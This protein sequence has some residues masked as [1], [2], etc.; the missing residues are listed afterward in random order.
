MSGLQVKAQPFNYILYYSK[1]RSLAIQIKAGEVVVRA[2]LA[3]AM[4]KIEAFLQHKQHW[5]LEKIQ[6]TQLLAA[7]K[8]LEEC[9]LPLFEQVLPFEV[10]RAKRSY[11]LQQQDKLVL[12][13]SSRVQMARVDII[14]Q[15]LITDWYKQQAQIWFNSRV[16]YW[17]RQ[18]QVKSTEIVI[19]GWLSKWG[20]CRA[21]G[22]LG[23][24]WR[25][26]MAPA[27]VA[28]YVVVHEV[29][30]LKHLNH[31]AAFWQLVAKHCADVSAAK[32]WLKQYQHHLSL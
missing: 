26:M 8:W 22:R 1:R 12:N 5:I 21:D 19:G 2:P 20:Y 25:L 29:C 24:N 15:Q 10:Q 30:H 31:S 18:L 14:K 4:A 6:T 3:Y 32:Q 17:Q 9:R 13:I 23:F 11:I 28:D 16:A 7:P 27:W